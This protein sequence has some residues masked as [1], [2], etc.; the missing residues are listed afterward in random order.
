MKNRWFVSLIVSCVFCFAAWT[1][2]ARLQR[3]P[4]PKWEYLIVKDV[5][6]PSSQQL[7]DRGLAGWELVSVVCLNRGATDNPDCVYHMKR[8]W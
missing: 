3:T 1:A 8:P 4:A 7:N 6:Y 2:H 5:A